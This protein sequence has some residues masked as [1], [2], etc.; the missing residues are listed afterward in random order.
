MASGLQTDALLQRHNKA[1][2]EVNVV[3]WRAKN[4]VGVQKN[5][6]VECEQLAMGYTQCIL[7]IHKKDR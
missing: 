3:H 1:K 6:H 2:S 4:G 7:K 5:K